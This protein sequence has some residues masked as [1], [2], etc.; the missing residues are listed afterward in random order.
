MV[1]SALEYE[2]LRIIQQIFMKRSGNGRQYIF[3]SYSYSLPSHC[4]IEM[5]Q[6][7]AVRPNEGYRIFS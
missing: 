6:Y 1:N 4:L 2:T 7:Q 3:G 5:L